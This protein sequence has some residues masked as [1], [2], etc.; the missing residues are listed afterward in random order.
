MVTSTLEYIYPDLIN[1]IDNYTRNRSNSLNELK[2]EI[3]INR[4][5]DKNINVVDFA[6][7][8]G[9]TRHKNMKI[10][11]KMIPYTE[12]RGTSFQFECNN[13]SYTAIVVC[14]GHGKRY[15][16]AQ[17]VVNLFCIYFPLI[18]SN[19]INMIEA[20][21]NTNMFI[22]NETLVYDEQIINS[23]CTFTCCVIDILNNCAFFA[24]K[25]DSVGR[26]L[27]KNENLQTYHTIYRTTDHDASNILEQHRIYNIAPY[28]KFYSNDKTLR[29]NGDIVPVRGFGDWFRD[30]PK[31]IIGRDL[32]IKCVQLIKSDIIII[33]SDGL[34]ET[35]DGSDIIS[36]RNDNEIDL[37]VNKWINYTSSKISLAKFL[38][39]EHVEYMIDKYYESN[40]G[41]V[42]INNLRSTI[43][44]SK[45]NTTVLIYT[46]T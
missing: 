33:S 38:I 1:K 24:N 13:K 18:L 43:R 21:N 16:C 15:Q 44:N 8:E 34:Y 14:D 23:G 5:Y 39:N 7:D 42:D 30:K 46:V 27:R 35:V 28:V 6:Q 2:L 41:N 40:S 26:I 31:G 29:L 20:L 12:D 3:N 17:I 32:D 45:D 9:Y 36:G 25:G 19:S 37:D 11:H 22:E 4:N 10:G